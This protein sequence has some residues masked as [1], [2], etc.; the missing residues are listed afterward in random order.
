[1]SN[2]KIII[3]YL[4]AICYVMG[5]FY[6][7]KLFFQF[8]HLNWIVISPLINDPLIKKAII[9]LVISYVSRLYAKDMIR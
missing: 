8:I 3:A 6:G 2:L 5:L 7:F 9:A 1:M 4:L